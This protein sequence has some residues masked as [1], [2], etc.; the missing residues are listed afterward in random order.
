MIIKMQRN[1]KKM[2]I[3]CY[4]EVNS[5]HFLYCKKFYYEN[6]KDAIKQKDEEIKHI[7]K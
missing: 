4:S 7:E 2:K 3:P 5:W 1:I 6:F